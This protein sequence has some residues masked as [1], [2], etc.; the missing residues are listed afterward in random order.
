M[1]YPAGGNADS[2]GRL[3]ADRLSQALGQQVIVE[4]R[5]GAGATIGAQAV[6][7][8]PADGYTLLLAP[9]AVV[10]GGTGTLT[11]RGCLICWAC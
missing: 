2:I 4:N 5:A 7:R 8:S 1:P 6:A 10:P 11:M 9:T 3:L